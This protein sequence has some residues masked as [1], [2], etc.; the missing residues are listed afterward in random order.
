MEEAL[1]KLIFEYLRDNLEVKISSNGYGDN[2]WLEI[3]LLLEDQI[4]STYSTYC[5]DI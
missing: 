5:I 2:A 3:E 1:K 4:I